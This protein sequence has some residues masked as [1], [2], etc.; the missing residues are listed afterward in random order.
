[1]SRTP[2]AFPAKLE[3]TESLV[4]A[5]GRFGGR[6]SAELLAQLAEVSALRLP[7]VVTHLKRDMADDAGGLDQGRGSAV[8][9]L[10][11]SIAPGVNVEAQGGGH[12]AMF[13]ALGAL[14]NRGQQR[15]RR[16]SF[17][18]PKRDS[19]KPATAASPR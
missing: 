2:C 10:V 19:R 13:G 14:V 4:E 17:D 8:Q 5:R 12:P 11:E 7:F 1:M 18:Y 9:L 6:D 3:I 16:A 15:C